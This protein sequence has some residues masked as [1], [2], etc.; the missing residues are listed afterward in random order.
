MCVVATVQSDGH[1]GRSLAAYG[2]IFVAG[3]IARGMVADGHRPVRRHRRPGP[4]R[5]HAV[6]M[7]ATPQP[8]T[9]QRPL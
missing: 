1:F 7:Y 3:S 8:L 6:I 5:R 9:R 2:G 4:P